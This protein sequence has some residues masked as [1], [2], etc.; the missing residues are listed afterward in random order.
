MR[1]DCAGADVASMISRDVEEVIKNALVKITTSPLSRIDAKFVQSLQAGGES[2]WSELQDELREYGLLADMISTAQR[3]SLITN[4]ITTM[5][6]YDVNS[7]SEDNRESEP[8]PINSDGSEAQAEVTGIPGA[9]GPNVAITDT[10]RQIEPIK[11]IRRPLIVSNTHEGWEKA[12]R[13]EQG[14]R[15]TP[16]FRLQ[17]AGDLQDAEEQR[18]SVV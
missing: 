17:T 2:V 12:A 14:P 6:G 7:E 16:T 8:E 11:P 18:R 1:L 9:S 13:T 4:L 15:R 10:K 3:R 5:V